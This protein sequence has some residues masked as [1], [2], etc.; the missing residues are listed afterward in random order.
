MKKQLLFLTACILGANVAMAQ[1]AGQVATNMG[2]GGAD[3][4][5]TAGAIA[6]L[7]GPIS[8]AKA[9]RTFNPEEFQGSPYT[10]N[11]FLPTRVFYKDEDMGALYYRYNAYNGEIEVKESPAQDGIRALGR[12]K[13]IAI[14]D[15][16]NRMSFKTYIDRNKNTLN[17]YLTQLVDGE[18]YDLYR[19]IR[20]KYTEG[21]KAANSFVK[22]IPSRFSQFTEYYVQK[23]GINRIDEFEGNNRSLYR[24]VGSENKD[25]LK[26]FIKE[27]NL[28]PKDEQDL[29]R[30]FQHL[31][32]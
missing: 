13:N 6:T 5:G 15:G 16:K 23:E 29:I 7:L 11:N 26:S 3:Q 12:D 9:K 25:A 19:R 28:N 10:N 17:G 18:N 30:I 1:Y 4:S 14:L 2:G 27:N 8:D 32:K 31:N 22:A 20:I 21:Q 24:L